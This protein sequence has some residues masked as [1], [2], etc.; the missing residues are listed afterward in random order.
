[1]GLPVLNNDFIFAWQFDRD[2]NINRSIFFRFRLSRLTAALVFGLP[3][4]TVVWYAA[5]TF[6]LDALVLDP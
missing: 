6:L 1:M 3:S 5:L 4:S 2:T